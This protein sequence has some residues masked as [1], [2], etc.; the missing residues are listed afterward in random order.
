MDW[1]LRGLEWGKGSRHVYLRRIQAQVPEHQH[2]NFFN[3]VDPRYLQ[4]RALYKRCLHQSTRTCRLMAYTVLLTTVRL[5]V[6]QLKNQRLRFPKF[7]EEISSTR[8][9]T[10]LDFGTIRSLTLPLS[11]ASIITITNHS[12]RWWPELFE[13]I[14]SS[15]NWIEEDW[16]IIPM[17]FGN[18]RSHNHVHVHSTW[19]DEWVGKAKTVLKPK[20]CYW[21]SVLCRVR[22]TSIPCQLRYM[23]SNVLSSFAVHKQTHFKK[24]QIWYIFMF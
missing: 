17:L 21:S 20:H 2:Q 15:R 4:Q 6:S 24:E 8:N 7:A 19:T 13:E 3:T 23:S 5:L 1:Q 10:P 11:T 12:C 22:F 16:F 18:I 9:W 14:K